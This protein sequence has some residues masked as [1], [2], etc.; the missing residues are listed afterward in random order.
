MK[1]E[2]YVDNSGQP[3]VKEPVDPAKLIQKIS[4]VALV[5]LIVVFIIYFLYKKNKNGKCTSIENTYKNAAQQIAE[6]N[7][8]LPK[9]NG[10]SITITS[11]E[12]D[13]SGKVSKERVTLKEDVCKGS[14][15]IT[16][17]K[18]KYVK[19]A[20]L[21]NCDYCTTDT[22]YKEFGKWTDKEPKENDYVE[23]KTT[24]NYYTFD[25]YYTEYSNWLEES[26]V[27]KTKD[28]KLG[29]YLPKDKDYIPEVPT[30]GK[31][32]TVEQDRKNTY[33][34]RDKE[35]LYY[36]VPN[37]NYSAYS[38]E[39]VPGYANKDEDSM[40][41]SKASDW[42]P[43]YPDEK[44][45]RV[46][47]SSD[48]YRWYKEVNGKKVYWKNG[49]YYPTKPGKGY[50]KD[51]SKEVTVYSYVD[52]LYRYYNGAP[53][54]YGGYDSTASEYFPYRDDDSMTYTSWSTYD[55]VSSLDGTNNW[56]REEK[57]NVNSRYRVKYKIYSVLHLDNYMLQ[58]EMETKIGKTLAQLVSEPN[59]EL[60]TKYQYRYR[61]VK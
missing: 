50:K 11:D 56:Y 21:T 35:W 1:Q 17:V 7:S 15:T 51:T 30:P 44:D 34:Y 52:D 57:I 48:G 58:K 16:K 22:H 42:S 41:E 55:D 24:Y 26:E 10:E 39:P 53:R 31:V 8:K 6:Q 36:S 59:V 49:K 20:N 40:I 18:G 45:Y 38:N 60:K 29:I 2:G 32:I 14:V 23:V 9:L 3:I 54:E 19:T 4:I 43:N 25:T 37:N 12:I 61:K 33:S 13:K 28:K 47:D 46:I 27:E 5:V